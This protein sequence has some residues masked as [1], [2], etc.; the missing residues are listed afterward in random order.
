MTVALSDD[1]DV[2][3]HGLEAMLA[4]F[5]DRVRILELDVHASTI[6]P[7]QVT[8][9]DTFARNHVGGPGMAELLSNPNNGRVVVYS[10]NDHPDLVQRALKQGCAGYLDKSLGAEE[11]V[12][13]IERVAAGEVVFPSTDGAPEVGEPK[14][15]WPGQE[16][17]L[18]SREAEILALITQGMTN[19]DIAIRVYLSVNTVK[20][21]I[22]RAYHK[23][24]VTRRTQA[25]RWGAEHG[26]LPT[27]T[28]DLR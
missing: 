23:I 12:E 4:P 15:A 24:G 21:H 9:Y 8:L 26:M 16:H 1:Y 14:G 7:V 27:R 3:V 17:G 13:A 11:L 2:V 20:S 19:E 18:T 25:V 6:T 28:R 5:A 22:R 10:W